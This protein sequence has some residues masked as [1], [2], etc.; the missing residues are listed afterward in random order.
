M[1]SFIRVSAAV[2]GLA[3]A[4]S[5]LA[6]HSNQV[7]HINMHDAQVRFTNATVVSVA[8]GVKAG[9]VAIVPPGTSITVQA[10]YNISASTNPAS[11][12]GP[13]SCPGCFIQQ[14]VA[15]TPAAV[16][17]GAGTVN[18]LLWDG[19]NPE[20]GFLDTIVGATSGTFTF[21]TTAPTVPGEYYISNGFGLDFGPNPNVASGLGWDLSAGVVGPPIFA[22]FM[23]SVTST[24]P[25]ICAGDSNG[26]G[27]VNFGD[28]TSVLV[29]FGSMCP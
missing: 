1:S 14:Y 20:P 8:S 28:I 19:Q 18:Q 21:S 29:N 10:S 17:A 13:G 22:G 15:W 4:S 26:D 6:Q 25:I 12:T 9:N 2:C 24:P 23:I 3:L 7:V 16:A 27:V 11:Y 5:A